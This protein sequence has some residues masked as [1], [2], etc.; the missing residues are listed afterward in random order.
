ME[1]GKL[2]NLRVLDVAE[3]DLASLPFT[4]N[5]LYERKILSALW[6]S[7]HQPPLPRLSATYDPI[8]NVKV[9]KGRRVMFVCGGGLWTPKIY[10]KRLSANFFTSYKQKP[11]FLFF[12]VLTCCYLPQ[13]DR[14]MLVRQRSRSTIAGPRVCFG[15]KEIGVADDGQ[16]IIADDDE[17]N[18]P[19]GK[20]ERYDTPR[21]FA[22]TAVAA[23]ESI[24][25]QQIAFLIAAAACRS[26]TVWSEKSRTTSVGRFHSGGGGGWRRRS[27]PS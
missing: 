1:I 12:E 20:F 17:E 18:L 27:R 26:K 8:S 16:P 25:R 13:R 21:K 5:V 4:I 10:Y 9:R 22:Q 11:F 6:L 3:N 14:E 24:C 23:A 19:I 2:E 15:Q 7:L